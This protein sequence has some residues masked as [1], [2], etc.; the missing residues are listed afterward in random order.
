MLSAKPGQEARQQFLVGL[1]SMPMASTHVTKYLTAPTTDRFT[2]A[3]GPEASMPESSTYKY[4]HVL[5]LQ[6]KDTRIFDNDIMFSMNLILTC[7]D[8]LE[9][10]AIQIQNPISKIQ[11]SQHPPK[12]INNS[13]NQKKHPTIPK[14]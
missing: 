6:N 7:F 4:Q 11:K 9:V 2:A 14:S 5:S 12:K 1:N 10:L 13:K 3:A 8:I